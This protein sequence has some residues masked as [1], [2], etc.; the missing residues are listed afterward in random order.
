[1]CV[2]N[3]F[4]FESNALIM[5]A[6][7]TSFTLRGPFRR[8]ELS[9]ILSICSPFDEAVCFEVVRL[10]PKYSAYH[11]YICIYV[12]TYLQRETLHLSSL[13]PIGSACRWAQTVTVRYISA[14]VVDRA[15]G[16]IFS[17]R[18]SLFLFIRITLPIVSP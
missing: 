11:N 1:M 6:L 2:H 5:E 17:I 12:R 4:L 13:C 15:S 8:G 14:A 3:V 16:G 7:P 9:F 18:S 10:H